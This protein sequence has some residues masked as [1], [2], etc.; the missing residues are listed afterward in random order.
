L[1]DNIVST[2]NAMNFEG[3]WLTR[4]GRLATITG[5]PEGNLYSGTMP[6]FALPLTWHTVTG[7]NA[8]NVMLDLVER[9]SNRWAKDRRGE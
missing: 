1:S 2:D 4:D 9:V 6:D 3:T 8:S 5:P 7:N